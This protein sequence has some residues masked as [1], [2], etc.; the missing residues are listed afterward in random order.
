M[1]RFPEVR[2]DASYPSHFQDT[3][4]SGRT[5]RQDISSYE[6]MD[7]GLTIKTREGDIVTLSTSRFSSLNA[8]EYT[9]RGSLATQE[10]QVAASYSER[11]IELASGQTFSFSV[12]GDLNEQELAD[13]ES[14]VSGIDSIVYEMAEGDMDEAVALALSMGSYDS[15]SMY[16]ADIT[17]TRAYSAY[18][19]AATTESTPS[20]GASQ[21]RSG[22]GTSF[23]PSMNTAFT[24]DVSRFLKDQEANAL[25]H[26]QRPLSQL[27]DYYLEQQADQKD[28]LAASNDGT[29]FAE[30]ALKGPAATAL[31]NTAKTVDL[32][33]QEMIKA[34][35]DKTLNEMV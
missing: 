26:A 10:G 32:L 9:S 17:L 16:E 25:A 3:G 6:S 15:V 13:I 27:F 23:L 28:A 35:F 7:A 34:V 5:T 30:T 18:T 21:G 22:Y 12:E 19:E 4:F 29:N 11:Q 2:S 1:N 31:E 14:I 33:I 24:E 8:H 20:L